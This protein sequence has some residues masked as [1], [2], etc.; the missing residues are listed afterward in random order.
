MGLFK[1]K[2]LKIKVNGGLPKREPRKEC[3]GKTLGEYIKYETKEKSNIVAALNNIDD[4]IDPAEKRLSFKIMYYWDSF[5][6][7]N[8]HKGAIESLWHEL[9]KVY[10]GK[11]PNDMEFDLMYLAA[12]TVECGT[13][14]VK[15]GHLDDDV[16]HLAHESLSKKLEMKFLDA[17]S[18]IVKWF[19]FRARYYDVLKIGSTETELAYLREIINNYSEEIADVKSRSP[20]LFLNLS[21]LIIY[22]F[23]NKPKLLDSY[24]DDF[25][26]DILLQ[27]IVVCRNLGELEEMS[28]NIIIYQKQKMKNHPIISWCLSFFAGYGEKP[29]RLLRLYF[30]LHVV[31][32]VILLSPL[33]NIKT[34]SNTS[35]ADKLVDIIYFNNTT[36]LTIGYGDLTPNNM[37]AKI[38]V[39]IEQTMGFLTGGS[40]VTLFLRK[41][42]RF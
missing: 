31:F 37:P 23:N 24:Y 28:S 15:R 6:D 38:L 42:F 17:L 9:V 29:L 4:D 27:R 20:W 32:G 39:I 33:I 11:N 40:F 10:Q 35:L 12:L 25:Y 21:K 41:L 7:L 18:E 36:M 2:K 16:I 19:N 34:L 3:F 30:L 26:L 8:Q 14:Q 22:F 13:D 5:E 1:K